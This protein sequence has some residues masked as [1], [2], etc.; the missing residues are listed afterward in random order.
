MSIGEH[1]TEDSA[2]LREAILLHH[3]V[4]ALSDEELGETNL[5]EHEIKLTAIMTS[6]R[7]LPYA[8]CTELEEELKR[9]LNTG[10]IEL[11]VSP[12]SCGLVLVRKKD[13]SL[14][15]CVDY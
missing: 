4:F 13:G 15:V 7:C 12:Y 3:S 9:L 2:A 10:C 14:R 1:G 5:V 6:P 11:S 8:L